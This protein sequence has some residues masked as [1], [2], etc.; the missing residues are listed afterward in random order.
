[1]RILFAIDSLRKGGKEHQFS[2]LVKALL[3]KGHHISIVCCDR[4]VEFSE[5][6]NPQIKYYFISHF[7]RKSLLASLRILRIVIADRPSLIHAW[8]VYSS[9]SCVLASKFKGV[10]LVNGSLRTVFSHRNFYSKVITEVSYLLCHSVLANSYAGLHS[11]NKVENKKYRVI[12]NGFDFNRFNMA[13]GNS[14]ML[15]EGNINVTM[16]ANYSVFKDFQ[17][18]L[19]AISILVEKFQEVRFF[20]VGKGVPQ[21]LSHLADPSLKKF[22]Q[23]LDGSENVGSLLSSTDIGVLSTHTEGISNTVMEYMAFGKPVVATKVGGM[24]ELVIDQENGFLVAHNSPQDLADKLIC[25]LKDPRLRARMGAAG[26]KRIATAFSLEAMVKRYLA[27]YEVL[28][29]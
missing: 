15:E 19:N 27:L 10:P 14:K 28:Q 17:T 25:L 23:L 12:P 2:Y 21:N 13:S 5:L 20:L 8:D 18:M 26:K 1:M 6:Q 11:V 3:E 22:V 7:Q 29:K 24:S 16:L 9:L 4:E